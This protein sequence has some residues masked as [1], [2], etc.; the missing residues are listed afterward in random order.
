MNR[1]KKKTA[2]EKNAEG[3]KRTAISLLAYREHTQ[4]ELFEKLLD[5]GFS[6]ED[7]EGAVAFAVEKNY[8]SEQ[9]YYTRF[10][11]F[12]AK[13]KLYGRR[14]IYQEARK[15]G[16]SADAIDLY[17]EEALLEVNFDEICFQALQ[18][19]HSATKERQTSHL[20]RRGFSV[21]NIRYAFE[22]YQ[23]EVGPL[24]QNDEGQDYEIDLDDCD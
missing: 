15:K 14:R 23:N 2:V 24:W 22:K 21:S 13:S 3:A 10:V 12:C 16:F 7:A 8:L 19:I 5:R 17:T 6:R 11:E 18:N 9:R 1:N 20:L 4:K